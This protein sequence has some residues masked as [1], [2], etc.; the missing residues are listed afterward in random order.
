MM[1]TVELT[2]TSITTQVNSDTYLGTGKGLLERWGLSEV[3]VLVL[4]LPFH[5]WAM[6][7]Q[8]C[9]LAQPAVHHKKGYILETL[10]L[11]VLFCYNMVLDECGGSVLG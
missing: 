1:A 2:G 11:H 4:V 5:C 7:V 6:R 9:P 8:S 3:Q 10:S